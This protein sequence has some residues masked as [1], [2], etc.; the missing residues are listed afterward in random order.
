MHTDVA[1]VDAIECIIYR[2]L[3]SSVEETLFPSRVMQL[4]LRGGAVRSYKASEAAEERPQCSKEAMKQ[5][6]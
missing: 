3:V 5:L 1:D 4:R 2:A 6:Q